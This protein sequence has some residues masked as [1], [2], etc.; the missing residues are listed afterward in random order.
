MLPK[1]FFHRYQTHRFRPSDGSVFS[2][3]LGPFGAVVPLGFI[4]LE[5]WFWGLLFL[6]SQDG[7]LVLGLDFAKVLPKAFFYKIQILDFRPLNGFVFGPFEAAI[8]LHFADL[9]PDL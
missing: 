7:R 8:S 9:R 4:I 1:A 2:L 3:F 5:C 6:L